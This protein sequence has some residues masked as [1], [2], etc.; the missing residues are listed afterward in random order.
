MQCRFLSF[1]FVC[2]AFL[3]NP[4]T[5]R[6]IGLDVHAQWAEWAHAARDP[7]G[8]RPDVPGVMHVLEAR[9]AEAWEQLGS[10]LASKAAAAPPLEVWAWPTGGRGGGTSGAHGFVC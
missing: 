5:I 8:R 1:C 10:V 9:V 2:L 6:H 7:R 4:S 3:V